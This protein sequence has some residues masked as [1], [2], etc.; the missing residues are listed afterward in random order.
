M[1]QRTFV[2]LNPDDINN[3]ITFLHGTSFN[4]ICGEAVT[5]WSQVQ[6]PVEI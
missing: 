4:I 5:L 1:I 2:V 3:F 6:F